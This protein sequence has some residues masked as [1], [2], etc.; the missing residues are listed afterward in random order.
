MALLKGSQIVLECEGY[1]C[2]SAS[3][4]LKSLCLNCSSIYCEPCWDKQGP[5]QPGKAGPDGL[6]H[7]RT[8]KEIYERLKRIL[9]PPENVVELSRLHQEDESTT[10]FGIEKKSQWPPNIPGSW[11]LRFAHG[12]HEATKW[13]HEIPSTSFLCWRDR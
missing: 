9:D 13:W 11:S 12:K 8:D 4:I 3:S 10:W 5:H 6:P 1:G 7:E 2:T